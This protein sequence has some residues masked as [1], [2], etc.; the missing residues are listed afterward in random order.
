MK[1]SKT[2]QNVERNI[3]SQCPES[4]VCVYRNS[5]AKEICE[6]LAMSYTSYNYKLLLKKICNTHYNHNLQKL[7]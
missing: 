6:I 7:K 3:C 5:K 2:L 1:K 4:I